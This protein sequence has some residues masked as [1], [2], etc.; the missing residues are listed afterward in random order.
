MVQPVPTKA[1]LQPATAAAM[2][3]VPC[4]ETCPPLPIP[5]FLLVQN[6]SSKRIAPTDKMRLKSDDAI[7]RHQWLKGLTTFQGENINICQH[8]SKCI[9]THSCFKL[10]SMA[11]GIEGQNFEVPR[12]GKYV[13]NY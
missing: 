10:L 3:T 4:A 5:P 9:R 7:W 1:F 2:C 12:T 13:F 6:L 8:F 11:S